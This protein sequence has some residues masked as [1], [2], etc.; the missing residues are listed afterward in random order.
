MGSILF[1]AAS[2]R[3][4][5]PNCELMIHRGFLVL[6]G[7]ATTVQS[8]AVWT[9]KKDQM[10]LHLYAARACA[11]EF[12]RSRDMTEQQTVKF[13][14]DKIKKFGDWNLTAEEAVYYGF[15]DGVLGDPGFETLEKI[16]RG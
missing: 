2:K 7:V 8:N 4:M 1:Q 12:C 10:M 3:V 13:I 16:R 9:K 15:C 5:T 6:E 14:D 11:G